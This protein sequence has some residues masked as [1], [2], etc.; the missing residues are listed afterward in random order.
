MVEG[1]A[2]LPRGMV[3]GP[4]YTMWLQGSWSSAS[5]ARGEW[6]QVKNLGTMSPGPAMELLWKRRAG[7]AA[8]MGPLP[9]GHSHPEAH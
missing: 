2:Q 3:P 9:G 7:Q 8:P 5:W 6:E 1:K 4:W